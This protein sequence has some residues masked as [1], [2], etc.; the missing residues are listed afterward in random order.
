MREFGCEL[1]AVTVK[2][3]NEPALLSVV[4]MV[5][6]SE[7]QREQLRWRWKTAQSTVAKVMG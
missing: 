5:A 7:R 1:E 6:R 4:G 2:T 3:D